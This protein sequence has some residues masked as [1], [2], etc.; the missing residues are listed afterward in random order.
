MIKMRPD[1]VVSRFHVHTLVQTMHCALC[2]VHCAAQLGASAVIV[3]VD[4]KTLYTSGVAITL[5]NPPH[6]AAVRGEP[7]LRT[8]KVHTL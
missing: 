2:T 8:K 1:C 4:A 6:T 5:H 3:R 7:R